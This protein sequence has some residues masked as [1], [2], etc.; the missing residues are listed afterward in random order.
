MRLVLAHNLRLSSGEDE[1][2][3]DSPATIEAIGAALRELGHDVEPL[4]VTGTTAR[5]AA[6]LEAAAPDLVVNLAA[7]RR[8]RYREAFSS[9]SSGSLTRARTRTRAP[10]A[11]TRR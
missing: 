7:G 8:G 6:R 1:A 9:T 2:E 10:S 5:L 4:E 11:S 3:F